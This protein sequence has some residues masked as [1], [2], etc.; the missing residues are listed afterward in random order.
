LQL[1]RRVLGF[2]GAPAVIAMHFFA[3]WYSKPSLSGPEPALFH[4][5]GEDDLAVIAQHYDVPVL[6]VRCA[7]GQG[8]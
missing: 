6:S 7:I 5:T 3:Y 8:A 1:V 2:P 4:N